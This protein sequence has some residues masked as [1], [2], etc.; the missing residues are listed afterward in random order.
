MKLS[1]ILFTVLFASVG[2]VINDDVTTSKTSGEFTSGELGSSEDQN[3]TSDDSSACNNWYLKYY[4]G[5][6]TCVGHKP[7]EIA[8]ISVRE[9]Y[10]V[11]GIGGAVRFGLHHVT[12]TI[13]AGSGKSV[14]RVFI[15]YHDVETG[16]KT[17]VTQKDFGS[18][19]AQSI[20]RT[21]TCMK[22]VAISPITVTVVDDVFTDNPNPK[23]PCGCA[24]ADGSP[25]DYSDENY[26]DM[27][28][29]EYVIVLQ[30]DP[31]FC[32]ESEDLDCNS[33]S[34]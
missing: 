24:S 1:L 28:V 29:V 25:D 30:C 5:N 14:Q 7:W 3:M 33:F 21:A 2:S 9:Q 32:P 18:G 34:H 10:Y 15:E 4:K 17:C 22:N 6:Y 8:P 27:N 12:K 19:D 13:W 23:P 31:D 20:Y 16:I 26:D 11:E